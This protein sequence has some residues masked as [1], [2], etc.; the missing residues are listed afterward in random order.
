MMHISLHT[1][2]VCLFQFVGILITQQASPVIIK[3]Q[4]RN[5]HSI[6]EHWSGPSGEPS[7]EPNLT[8]DSAHKARRFGECDEEKLNFLCTQGS[9]RSVS[10]RFHVSAKNWFAFCPTQWPTD[11]LINL[12]ELFMFP[13]V[14]FTHDQPE[15][16]KLLISVF[17]EKSISC[18]SPA[19]SPM[20]TSSKLLS[21]ETPDPWLNHKPSPLAISAHRVKV[22]WLN[23]EAPL[24]S[25]RL[26]HEC[27]RHRRKFSTDSSLNKH[28]TVNVPARM[29]ERVR[30]TACT[31]N[32]I[33]NRSHWPHL[34]P[35]T[36]PDMQIIILDVCWCEW[37]CGCGW[38]NVSYSIMI[39]L[40]N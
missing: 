36:N 14:T 7:R 40:F 10:K 31:L 23:P 20:F 26:V 32:L 4:V 3:F 39:N 11:T 37:V 5:A 1:P 2:L 30:S 29:D 6:A 22:F 18:N 34:S 19:L 9:R 8:I 33:K 15:Q 28:G 16:S 38:M 21:H 17:P 25:L 24:A 35:I 27:S 13:S 12:H